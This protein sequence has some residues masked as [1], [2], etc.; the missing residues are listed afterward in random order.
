MHN[1]GVLFIASIAHRTNCPSHS[2]KRQQWESAAA[3]LAKAE[4]QEGEP[5]AALMARTKE[6]KKGV[7]A[8]PPAKR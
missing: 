2:R 8:P 3:P 1:A 5:S 6:V 7:K 4:A